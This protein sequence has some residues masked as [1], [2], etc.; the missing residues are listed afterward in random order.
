MAVIPDELVAKAGNVPVVGGRP[1]SLGRLPHHDD[2]P[3]IARIPVLHC[4]Q[5]GQDLVVVVAVLERDH[6]PAV[7]RPL[8]L[9]HVALGELRSDDAA[10]ERIVDTGVV[11]RE[12]DAQPLANLLRQRLGLQLLRMPLGHGELALE[13]DDF[14]RIVSA[15]EVPEGRLARCRGDADPRRSAVDVVGQIG[16]LRVPGQRADAADLGLGEQGVVRPA[17]CP[18]SSVARAPRPRRNPS[19]SIAS[20]PTLGSTA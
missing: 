4:P 5:G 14:Q 10:D 12:Q 3:A 16:G 11:V 2:R 6:V 18:A 1:P 9:D 17:R 20:M 13:R 8:V 7:R 19:A 15:N